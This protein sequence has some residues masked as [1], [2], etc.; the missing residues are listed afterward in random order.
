MAVRTMKKGEEVSLTVKPLYGFGETG[1]PADGDKS[2]V[3][4]NAILEI[5]FELISWKTVIEVTEDKMVLKKIMKEGEGYK[6]P[7]DGADVK[8]KLTCK[9]KDGTMF[10]R[11]GHGG[12]EAE[13]FE[14]TTDEAQVTRGLDRAVMSMK[15]G[16]VASLTIAPKYGFGSSE[17][18]Q[19]LAVVPANSTLHYEVELVSF[20][21]RME[22]EKRSKFRK[23]LRDAVREWSQTKPK[24]EKN[25]DFYHINTHKVKLS[26]PGKECFPIVIGKYKWQLKAM[27]LEGKD[28]M[29]LEFSIY[30]M[31]GNIDNLYQVGGVDSFLVSIATLHPRYSDYM[32]H[33]NDD[34]KYCGGVGVHFFELIHKNAY[35]SGDKSFED[36]EGFVNFEIQVQAISSEVY[37]PF[38]SLT[39][40]MEMF[41]ANREFVLAQCSKFMKETQTEFKKVINNS[42]RWSSLCDLLKDENYIALEFQS[43]SVKVDVTNKRLVETFYRDDKGEE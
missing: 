4:T 3:P 30:T 18:R 33:F 25:K 37:P 1:K 9:L 26:F 32:H 8:W 27:R 16:E 15:K 20:V 36:S 43:F 39:Y 6:R 29:D 12:D 7:K 22:D 21:K 23:T 14:F 31:R 34:I 38:L 2:A 17:S 24:S 11:K 10:F 40:K 19:E 41:E 13:L 42:S 35:S 28:P 5:K